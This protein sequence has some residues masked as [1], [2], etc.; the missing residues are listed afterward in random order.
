MIIFSRDTF[1]EQ[2]S[3]VIPTLYGPEGLSFSEVN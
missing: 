1:A 2:E 3:M